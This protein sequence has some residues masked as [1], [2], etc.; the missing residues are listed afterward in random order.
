MADVSKTGL[1]ST[2]LNVLTRDEMNVGAREIKNE[3][4][5]FFKHLLFDTETS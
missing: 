2:R 3:R 4:F 5:E 1:N